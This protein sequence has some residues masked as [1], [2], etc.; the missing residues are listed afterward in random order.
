MSRIDEENRKKNLFLLDELLSHIEKRWP[1]VRFV[2]SDSIAE[3]YA[4]EGELLENE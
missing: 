3:M 1:E 2:S 4:D